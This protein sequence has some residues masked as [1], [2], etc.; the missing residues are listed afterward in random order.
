MKKIIIGLLVV[1]FYVSKAQTS[2]VQI[3][4]LYSIHSSAIDTT[5]IRLMIGFQINN[6]GQ[7]QTAHFLFGS[8]VDSSDVLHLSAN[9]IYVNE[10]YYLTINNS[11]YPIERYDAYVEI[12]LSS[13]QYN[14]SNFISVYVED[15]S[16]LKTTYLHTS[17]H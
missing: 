12:T 15:E 6:P 7:A 13:S 14:N 8:A 4:S 17:L 1:C 3:M 11:Q 5:Q 9:F 16:N 2:Q 10:K